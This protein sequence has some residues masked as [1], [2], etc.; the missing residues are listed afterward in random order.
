LN[1][2][3]TA[4]ARLAS[5]LRLALKWY[6]IV[7]LLT[8]TTV[9]P[10]GYWFFAE[11]NG[12]NPDVVWQAPWIWVVSVTGL[13]LCTTP[14]F[15]VLEGCGLVAESAGCASSSKSPATSALAGTMRPL[16]PVGRAN[17]VHR[18]PAGGLVLAGEHQAPSRWSI[19]FRTGR[20]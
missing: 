15:A 14:L 7:R 5:L 18:R 20:A 17:R 1:G 11:K 2:D 9:G 4:K 6:G 16:V 3:P 12:Q 8:L 19:C 13:T 10:I